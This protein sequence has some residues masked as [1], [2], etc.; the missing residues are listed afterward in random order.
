MSKKDIDDLFSMLDRNKNNTLDY[1]EFIAAAID[2]KLALSD[3]K[4]KKCF[5]LFDKNKDG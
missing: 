4:I 2:K 1:T 3:E 5:A